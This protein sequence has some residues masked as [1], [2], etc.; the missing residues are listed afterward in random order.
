MPYAR[1][2]ASSVGEN[3]S[4]CHPDE[5]RD[6]RQKR[7][8]EIAEFDVNRRAVIQRSNGH[9]EQIVRGVRS[10]STTRSRSSCPV[11]MG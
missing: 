5:A 10:S 4:A 9:G 2:L 7:A 8:E 6:P 1:K 3:H 11:C